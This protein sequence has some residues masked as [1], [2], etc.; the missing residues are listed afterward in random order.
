MMYRNFAIGTLIAAPLVV[1]AVQSVLPKPPE[2]APTQQI[3]ADAPPPLVPVP[4]APPVAPPSAAANAPDFGQPMAEAGQ[5]M[6]TPGAGLPE[7]PVAPLVDSR[8]SF[9]PGTAP[10]GSPNA[11]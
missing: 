4:V 9:V 8:Q 5:P 3:I 7:T 2:A 10:A 11:E 6:L 1:L